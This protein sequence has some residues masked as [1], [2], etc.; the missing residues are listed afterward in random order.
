M[1]FK[2]FCEFEDDF[3]VEYVHL[4]CDVNL[5]CGFQF[6]LEKSICKQQKN[7]EKRKKNLV[8]V[9]SIGTKDTHL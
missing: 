3:V 7:N 8:L 1:I 2:Y 6:D 4:T 5:M 9:I